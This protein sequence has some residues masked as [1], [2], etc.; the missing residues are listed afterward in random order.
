LCAHATT[1]S[2]A[3]TEFGARGEACPV[4]WLMVV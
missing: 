1:T 3:A 2:C 4:C